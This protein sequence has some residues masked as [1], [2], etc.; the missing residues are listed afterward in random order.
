MYGSVGLLWSG[1]WQ[2]CQAA[3]DAVLNGSQIMQLPSEAVAAPHP[4]P[5]LNAY[6][7]RHLSKDPN[8]DDLHRVKTRSRFK[9]SAAKPKPRVDSGAEFDRSPSQEDE[10]MFSVETVECSLVNRAKTDRVLKAEGQ[11]DDGEVGLELSLG[12][13]HVCMGEGRIEIDGSGGDMCKMEMGF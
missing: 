2:H 6:D 11:I 13:P 8:S 7:I 10:S 5:P 9:R 1:N 3:V 4:I 12:F